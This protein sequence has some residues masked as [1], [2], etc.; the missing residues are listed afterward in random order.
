VR[1]PSLP[2]Y[3]ALTSGSTHGIDS[4]CTG[5]HVS[6]RN[7]VDQLEAAG[8]SWK[9]YM[10]GI[11][12]PCFGGASAGGY[13]KKHNPF[14]YYDD[15]AGNRARCQKI[16]PLD[17]L[18]EDLRRGALPTYVFI[19]P[20]LCDDMHDCGVATGDRFLAR[21]VR[22]FC[23]RSAVGAISCSRGTRAPRTAAAAADPGAAASPRSSPGRRSG[24]ER[25]PRSR[26]ITTA[27]CER[28]RTPS[29]C[30]GSAPPATRG[31]AT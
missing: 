18:V 11:P 27:C 7:I 31:T 5:C 14:A 26:S 17:R 24:A 30:R 16:V 3:L 29:A 1:P 6:S 10:E 2:D 8:I 4:D 28:S 20:N 12:R 9:A 22:S 19:S 15:V 13:A 25:A 21:L 23:T